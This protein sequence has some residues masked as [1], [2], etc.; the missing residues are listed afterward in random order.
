MWHDHDLSLSNLVGWKA[1]GRCNKLLLDGAD[2]F[3]PV[4]NPYRG[5]GP[6]L[7]PSCLVKIDLP[8]LPAVIV[9]LR[10]RTA[11]RRGRQNVCVWQTWQ[12]Y[13]LHVMSWS[14]LRINVLWFLQKDL[15]KGKWCLTKSYF[16][17]NCCHGCHTRFAV[18]FP[19]PSCC[20]S[21]LI[22]GT[23]GVCTDHCVG[24]A[25]CLMNL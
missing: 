17:Q 1:Y 15:F 8:I 3:P 7:I 4:L 16:K 19:L 23:G 12:G 6:L 10:N 22:P 21:S 5:G 18:F 11:G 2:L 25:T 20:V 24:I 14:P 9:S 13:N